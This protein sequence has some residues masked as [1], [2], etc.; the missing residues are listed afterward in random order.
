MTNYHLIFLRLIFSCYYSHDYVCSSYILAIDIWSLC[1]KFFGLYFPTFGLNT[2]IYI[3][4][5]HILSECSKMRT[6]K[7]S[8]MDTFLR[9]FLCYCCILLHNL[10]SFTEGTLP[11]G[12]SWNVKLLF[13]RWDSCSNMFKWYRQPLQISG[14]LIKLF[15]YVY[16]TEKLCIDGTDW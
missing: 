16:I 14:V 5:I 2:K 1:S 8:N 13:R 4:N 10:T 3:V 15:L 11:N 9:S 7:T 6:R 12:R